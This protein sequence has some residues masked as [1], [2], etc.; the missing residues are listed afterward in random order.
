MKRLIDSDPVTRTK[1][2]FHTDDSEGVDHV[3]SVQDVEPILNWNKARKNESDGWLSEKWGRHAATIP[4]IIIEQWLLEGI[5]VFDQNDWPEVK[6]R[7]NSNSWSHLR[8]S[9]W[10]I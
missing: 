7:L 6:R 8:T 10:V 9:E 2:W 4:N 3:E 1:M 5:N